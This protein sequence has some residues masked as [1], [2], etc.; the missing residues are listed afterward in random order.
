LAPE[1]WRVLHQAHQKRNI[2]EYDGEL[3][4]NASLLAQMIEVAG[5]ML[6]RCDA[7]GMPAGD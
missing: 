4:V 7:L 5:E 1:Q 3:D 2:A 6:R